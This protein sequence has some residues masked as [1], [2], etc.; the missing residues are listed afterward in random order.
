M[1]FLHNQQ[2]SKRLKREKS[3]FNR[4]KKYPDFIN[5]TQ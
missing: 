5:K 1:W 2:E 4:K 3:F